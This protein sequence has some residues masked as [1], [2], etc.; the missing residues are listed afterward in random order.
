VADARAE[1]IAENEDA[2]RHL[3]EQLGVMGFFA[4]ECGDAECRQWIEMPRERYSEIRR[5]PR[6]FFVRPGHELPDVEDVLERGDG[7]LLVAKRGD[8]SQ[9]ALKADERTPDDAQA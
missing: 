6:R 8:A 3:N 7:W 2:F 4:C 5:N 9:I 1:R